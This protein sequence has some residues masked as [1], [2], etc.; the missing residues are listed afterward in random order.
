MAIYNGKMVYII[1]FLKII[2]IYLIFIFN[3]Y[4]IYLFF[5]F[6]DICI[7]YPWN[8]H[9][10]KVFSNSDFCNNIYPNIF[11]QFNNVSIFK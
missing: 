10:A 11:S 5:R 9:D 4:T 7:G 3:I 2:L 1:I 8:V 6:K